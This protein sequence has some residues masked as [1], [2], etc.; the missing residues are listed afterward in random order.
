MEVDA[1]LPLQAEEFGLGKHA[2]ITCWRVVSAATVRHRLS[3]SMR[4]RSFI[5]RDMPSVQAILMNSVPN[6]AHSFFDIFSSQTP[7]RR[8]LRQFPSQPYKKFCPIK[9]LKQL[10]FWK[11]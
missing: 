9:K 3:V 6:R 2:I 10:I 1:P 5:S 7:P 11:H 8:V 4:P